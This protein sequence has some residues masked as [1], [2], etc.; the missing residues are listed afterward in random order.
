M[1]IISI[2]YPSLLMYT[3][4]TPHYCVVYSIRLSFLEFTIY[5]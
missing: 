4:I 5:K 3:I 1:F 2:M